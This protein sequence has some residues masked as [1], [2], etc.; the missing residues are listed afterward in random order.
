MSTLPATAPPKASKPTPDARLTQE[1]AFLRRRNA[2]LQ[3]DITTLT[4]EANRLHQLAQRL[5]GRMATPAPD[6]LGGRS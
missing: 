1:N 4:A 6:P 5:H 3:D 2:Q